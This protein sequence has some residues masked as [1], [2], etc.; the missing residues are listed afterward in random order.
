M[1]FLEVGTIV[2]PVQG[3]NAR[4]AF[5]IVEFNPLQFVL[6]RAC[7]VETGIAGWI[8]RHETGSLLFALTPAARIGDCIEIPGFRFVS[9]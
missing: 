1:K 2:G 8:T 4:R 5:R 3:S 9:V 6:S 7:F